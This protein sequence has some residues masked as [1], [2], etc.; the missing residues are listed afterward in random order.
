MSYEVF[1][2]QQQ[3]EKKNKGK[4]KSKIEMRK[5]FRVV[6]MSFILTVLMVSRTYAYV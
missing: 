6:D 3:Q 1:L 5:L 2:K 4:N